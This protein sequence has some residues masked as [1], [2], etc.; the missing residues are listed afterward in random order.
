MTTLES[1]AVDVV[2]NPAD[3]TELA[4]VPRTSPDEVA[5]LAA[6]LRAAQ[7]A[8]EALGVEGRAEWL[9]RWRDWLTEHQAQLIDLIQQETGKAFGDAASEPAYGGMVVQYWIHHAAEHLADEHPASTIPTQRLI[10]Q[11]RPFPL[12]GVITPWNWP[13]T[14]PLL[15]IPAALMAGSAVLSKPSELTPLSWGEAVRGWQEI[16]APDVL[17]IATGDGG[18]GAAVVDQVD[19]VQFTGSVRTGRA[20]AVRAAERLIP[21]GLELGGKDP[22][23]VLADADLERAANAAVWGSCVNA[24]Q[25]CSAVER[26]YVE[27]PAYDEFVRRAVEVTESLRLGTDRTEPLTVDVGAMSSEAQLKIVERHVADAVA[28][29]ARVL[30]GGSRAEGPG[31]YYRPTVI[32]DVTPDMDVMREETFGPVVAIQRVADVDEALRLSNDSAFGLCGSVWTGDRERGIALA[33]QVEV[34]AICVNDACVTNFQLDL[35][36]GGWKDS[37]IGARFGGADGI[38]KY[39]R[40][41]AVLST[42]AEPATEPHWYPF[43]PPAS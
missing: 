40:A 19:M 7:P 18:T 5:A 26:I 1:P 16:G 22:M 17:G 29:G 12:V 4:Q 20:V 37:G 13:I 42:L 8:W 25:G 38:R 35:P 39:T 10:I 3:G 15:D 32:V 30:V 6:R 41:R 11:H 21:C 27:A 28:A 31:W 9:A 23:I 43:G 36:S 34:G 2:R 14:M 24:G 33:S